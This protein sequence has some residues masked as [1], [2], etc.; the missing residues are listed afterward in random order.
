MR[1][2]FRKKFRI[3]LGQKYEIKHI[4]FVAFLDVLDFL[5]FDYSFYS[6]YRL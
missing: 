1:R 5:L 6:G 4:P 2:T 3:C